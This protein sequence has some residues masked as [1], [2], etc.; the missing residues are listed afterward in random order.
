MGRQREADRRHREQQRPETVVESFHGLE[1][2]GGVVAKRKGRFRDNHLRPDATRDVDMASQ[3]VADRRRRISQAA[4]AV[5][6]NGSSQNDPRQIP[7][8]STTSTSGRAF[9]NSLHILEVLGCELLV[10][11]VIST[12]CCDN[13]RHRKCGSF[14]SGFRLCFSSTFRMQSVCKSGIFSANEKSTS[15][16]NSAAKYRKLGRRR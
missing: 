4:T 1:R 7:R 5:A 14:S 3:P 12:G 10:V 15:A 2:D 6:A 9:S 13:A 8:Y 16:G 11:L